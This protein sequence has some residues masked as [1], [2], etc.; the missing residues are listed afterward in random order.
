SGSWDLA[1]MLS[2]HAAGIERLRASGHRKRHG[3]WKSWPIV[4]FGWSIVVNRMIGTGVCYARVASGHAPAAPSRMMS[5]R[6]TRT[7]I[8]AEPSIVTFGS[9]V[10]EAAKQETMTIPIREDVVA[11]GLMSYGASLPDLARR[12]AGYVHKIL[13]GTRPADLPA[14]QPAKFDLSVNLKTAKANTTV[15]S[16]TRL[17]PFT[18]GEVM[19]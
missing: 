6:L 11:G 19:C 3:G 15:Y 12:A 17:E 2:K 16:V 4:S 18:S 5:S 14:E 10:T 13:Q 7:P 1:R 8:D 9:P